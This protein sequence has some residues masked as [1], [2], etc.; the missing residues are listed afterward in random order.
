MNRSEGNLN[1]RIPLVT[2]IFIFIFIFTA[3]LY[4]G[5]GQEASNPEAQLKENYRQARAIFL[6]AKESFRQKSTDEA[7]AQFKHCTAVFP[8][9][10][11]AHYYLARIQ[12]QRQDFMVALQAIQSA[13]IH[14][15]F[16]KNLE[17]SLAQNE[18]EAARIQDEK[19]KLYADYLYLHG[20]ILFKTEQY[21]KAHRQYLETIRQNPLHA[22]AYN[23]LINLHYLLKNYPLA[24]EYLNQAEAAGVAVHTALKIEILKASGQM[25]DIEGWK[26]VLKN[27]Q[28]WTGKIVS[29]EGSLI[30]IH[31]EM[32]NLEFHRD[33]IMSIEPLAGETPPPPEAQPSSPVE[34][35]QAGPRLLR[36]AR[37]FFQLNFNQS[38][39][40]DQNYKELY[41]NNKF[42]VGLHIGYRVFRDLLLWLGY[43]STTAKSTIPILE[44][45][46]EAE[47]RFVSLELAYQL[48]LWKNLKFQLRLGIVP[49]QYKETVA[50]DE[51]KESAVGFQVGGDL[52]YHLNRS[53]YA[54]VAIGFLSASDTIGEKS[55][56]LG[57]LNAGLAIGLKF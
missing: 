26:I 32:G 33:G 42:F 9:Y 1:R 14:F 56:K 13:E 22:Q 49:I 46:S 12:Y 36:S 25:K 8:R 19:L 37:L 48:K 43:G 11:D 27:G 24:V 54:G 40:A 21:E 7:E 52:L 31:N 34:P 41:G 2:A 50:T 30:V 57:G 28:V 17:I 18:I 3:D 10:A 29:Q 23:N 6:K 55:V 47:Q 35:V 51:I 5:I 16:L 44:L 38:F 15:S 45:N 53:I 4:Q 20:N 39:P